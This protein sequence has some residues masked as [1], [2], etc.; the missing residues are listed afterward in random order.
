MRLQRQ[1]GYDAQQAFGERMS[2]ES[3]A[4]QSVQFWELM[5]RAQKLAL[6]AQSAALAKATGQ[7][8]SIV[9]ANSAG[10]AVMKAFAEFAQHPMALAAFQQTAW[11]DATKAWIDAWTGESPAVAD[12]RF[13]DKSWEADPISRGL[14][15]AH[16][17]VEAAAGKLLKSLPKESKD[18]L[19]SSTPGNC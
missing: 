18:H 9:D 13:R 2:P 17:A 15:D 19:R 11:R 6:S 3:A 8:F 16:L 7:E 1:S 12:R 5:Q 14:R 10:A 4:T